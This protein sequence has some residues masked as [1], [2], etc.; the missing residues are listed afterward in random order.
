[1]N[2]WMESQVGIGEALILDSRAQE[3][4]E[5]EELFFFSSK[6]R[7]AKRIRSQ[8]GQIICSENGN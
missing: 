5:F 1:M 4:I 8:S 2:N 6:V 7:Y 3:R